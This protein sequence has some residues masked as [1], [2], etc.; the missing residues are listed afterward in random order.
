MSAADIVKII[1][2]SS[3]GVALINWA[4]SSWT[5]RFQQRA[6][7]ALQTQK[8]QHEAK[9][10]RDAAHDDAR[11]AF[12]PIAECLALYFGRLAYDRHWEEVGVYVF[13]STERALLGSQGAVVD[14]ARSIMW[15]HPTEAVR[16]QARTIYDKLV[17][18]WYD[19]ERATAWDGRELSQTEANG[20]EQAAEELIRMIHA[21]KSSNVEPSASAPERR[22]ALAE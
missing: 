13:P 10:R 6:A 8:E 7:A 12:L 4:A 5:A 14:A 20:L 19:T 21:Q 22:P 17:S 18:Y 15:G 9:L 1:L 3:I 2:G 11:T 16:Q